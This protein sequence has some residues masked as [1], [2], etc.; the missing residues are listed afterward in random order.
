MAPFGTLKL[1]NQRQFSL[2]VLLAVILLFMVTV[3]FLP[4]PALDK[5][6]MTLIS[7]NEEISKFELR[8]QHQQVF[9]PARLR[10][11][12]SLLFFGYTHCP[13]ICPTAMATLKQVHARM[14][15]N[16]RN[17]QYVFVS[18][19]PERDTPAVLE[20]Y[21]GYFNREFLGV[22]GGHSELGA[23]TKS[24]GVYYQ[25]GATAAGADYAVDH[26]AAIFLIDPQ[27]RLRALFSAPQD[28]ER[29]A[30]QLR[31]LENS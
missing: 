22:S 19:D 24:L 31:S 28:A 7:R 29:M 6:G 16:N 20:K 21:T 23:L 26:S 30:Q 1:M 18:L 8:D 9:D 2:S 17:T 10:G 11:K 13:D 12:W 14:G 3:F 25:R 4:K 5:T 27:A 15:L